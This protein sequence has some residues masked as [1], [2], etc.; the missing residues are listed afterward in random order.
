MIHQNLKFLQDSLSDTQNIYSWSLSKEMQLLYS[1]CPEQDFFFSLFSISQ[2]AV[3]IRKYFT[4]HVLPLIASDQ[5]GFVW[6]AV[7]EN[8]IQENTIPVIHVLGPVFT[9]NMTEQYLI[10]RMNKQKLSTEITSRLW[11]YV[12][13]IPSISSDIAKRFAAMLHYCVNES[14]ITATDVEIWNETSSQEESIE[15]GAAAW[16]GDWTAEQQFFNSIVDGRIVDLDTITTGTI[17]N[18]SGGDPLRQAKNQLIIFAVLCSRAAIMGGV[19]VEGS[20][21][22]SDY[23][24]Q[25]A[26]SAKNIPAVEGLGLEMYHTYIQR[27]QKA[28]T[29][30]NYIPIVRACSEYVETHILERIKLKDMASFLGYTEHYISRTFKKETG[31]NLFDYINR[32]KIELSESMLQNPSHSIAAISEH[33]S[34][35]SPSYFSSIFKKITGMT[36][37]EYQNKKVGN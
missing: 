11:N 19:S 33:L 5:I 30:A 29:D 35:S 1:N 26:E 27:V 6:I 18:L 32:R 8:N 13:N 20:L 3:Q 15:W 24:I 9:S 37:I 12:R 10:Q 34:F 23:Y 22:L 4:D 28:K 25:S 16:H 2:C 17:G 7:L 14:T 31:E 21:N 36:P